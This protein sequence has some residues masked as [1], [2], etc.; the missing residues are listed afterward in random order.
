MRRADHA[1]YNFS[2]VKILSGWKEVASHLHQGVRTVQR[3]EAVGLPI[4]R[5][6]G[7][8]KSAVVAFA[9]ELDRWEEATPVRAPSEFAALKAKIDRLEVEVR[10]LKDA[11]EKERRKKT[12]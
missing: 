12:A 6:R 10:S 4:H 3:W 5:I 2:P 9:E 11:L 7:G 8:S 1:L